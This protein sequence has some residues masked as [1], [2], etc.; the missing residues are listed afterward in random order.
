MFRVLT[1]LVALAV[2]LAAVVVLVFWWRGERVPVPRH[3]TA[4]WR[5]EPPVVTTIPGGLLETASVRMTE[6]FYKADSR[7]WWGIYLGETVSHIQVAAVY[8]YG[9]PLTDDAWQIVTRGETSVVIA[10]V[11]RP[12]LPVAIDTATLQERTESGWLRFD[13]RLN[14]DEL[15]RGLSVDL[16]ERAMDPKRV[17]LVRDAARRTIGEFVERWL[18]SRGE[19]QAGA[20]SSVKVFFADEVDAGLLSQLR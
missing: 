5:A 7:T 11:L 1:R 4:E 10:P 2:V 8:R 13:K 12:S 18:L 3:W 17:A 20:F 15:R 16:E 14:L 9:V 19:W 6:D